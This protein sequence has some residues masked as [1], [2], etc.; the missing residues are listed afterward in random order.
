MSN[1]VLRIACTRILNMYQLSKRYV[2]NF[3]T[4]RKFKYDINWFAGF[5]R[6]SGNVKSC[7]DLELCLFVCFGKCYILSH[8]RGKVIN[9]F[10]F[11]CSL[12][13]VKVILP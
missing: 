12:M 4:S 8:T 11:G 9:I 5:A 10:T 6:T 13:Y 7:F 3:S 1:L 2:M